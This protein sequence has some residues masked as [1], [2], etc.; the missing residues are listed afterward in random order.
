MGYFDERS[1]VDAVVPVGAVT[2]T[3]DTVVQS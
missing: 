2:V 1:V 3:Q